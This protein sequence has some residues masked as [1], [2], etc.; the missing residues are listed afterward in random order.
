ME[1]EIRPYNLS[2]L[3]SVEKSSRL[4]GDTPSHT[5]GI[6]DNSLQSQRAGITF[7]TEC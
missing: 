2:Q 3:L 5:S 4:H 7:L 6:V 1:Q